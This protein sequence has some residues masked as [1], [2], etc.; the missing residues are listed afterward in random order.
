M[1]VYDGAVVLIDYTTGEILSMV[2]LPDFD[3]TAIDPRQEHGGASNDSLVN[4]CTIGQYSPGSIFYIATLGAAIDYLDDYET[5]TYVCTGSCKIDDIVVECDTAHGTMTIEDAFV[6]D[7]ATVMA[8]VGV[9]IGA[10]KMSRY[11]R[12]LLFNKRFDY[13]NIYMASSTFD[14]PIWEEDDGVAN[15]AIGQHDD[16]VT[17]LHIA[18]LVGALANDGYLMDPVLLGKINKRPVNMDKYGMRIFSKIAVEEL[19]YLMGISS[20]RSSDSV[21]IVGKSGLATVHSE[22][23]LLPNGWFVGYIDDA[24]HPL[25]VCVVTENSGD[26]DISAQVARDVMEYA[27]I[28]GY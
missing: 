26:S 28:M 7:C 24:S 20:D 14:V 1:T 2:S 4:R 25:A 18:M 9:D 5:M 10:A 12:Q 16:I 8:R 17:P 27:V 23:I 15:A 3:P 13:R 6:Y 19:S 11:A 21:E 22:D